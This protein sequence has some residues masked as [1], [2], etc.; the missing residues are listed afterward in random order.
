MYWMFVSFHIHKWDPSP[1]SDGIWRQVLW[2]VIRFISDHEGGASWWDW[3]KRHLRSVLPCEPQGEESRQQARKSGCTRSPIC[4]HLISGF[5][6]H[7]CEKFLITQKFWYFCYSQFPWKF[8]LCTVNF[9]PP[10]S[11]WTHSGRGRVAFSHTHTPTSHQDSSHQGHWWCPP[12]K[13]WG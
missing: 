5:Q 11:F 9:S 4:L 8:P 3:Q 12:V 2:E 13:N 10:I 7:K 6:P 1:Q